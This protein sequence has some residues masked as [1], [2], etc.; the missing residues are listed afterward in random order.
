[1]MVFLSSLGKSFGNTGQNENQQIPQYI[2][3]VLFCEVG[4]GCCGMVPK[5]VQCSNG[6]GI[7][8]LG[9]AGR[10]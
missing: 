1:M 2:I 3:T 5:A 6:Y 7:D 4:K 8:H 9:A 10:F